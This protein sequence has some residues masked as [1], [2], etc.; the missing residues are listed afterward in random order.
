MLAQIS[1]RNMCHGW[2]WNDSCEPL[3]TLMFN[4]YNVYLA[5]QLGL[6]CFANICQ[7]FKMLYNLYVC[8]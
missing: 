1:I 6:A 2:Y 8:L 7:L 5:H 4:W 3:P